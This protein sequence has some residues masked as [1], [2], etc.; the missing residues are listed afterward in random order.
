[1]TVKNLLYAGAAPDTGNLGVS[2]LCRAVVSNLLQLDSELNIYI[3]GHGKR[4]E[5]NAYDAGEG[6]CHILGAKLSNRVWEPSSLH[7]IRHTIKLGSLASSTARLFRQANALLDISGGDSFTDLYGQKRFDAVTLPK[8]IAIENNIP[9]ILLPQTYGPF[10]NPAIL[11]DSKEIV[12]RASAAYAR[13]R[14]SFEI[15]KEMLG[16]EFD[17][18]RHQ[19]AVDVA[20]LLPT[21]NDQMLID[22]RLLPADYEAESTREIAG[23]NVSGL[24]YNQPDKASSQYG[25]TLDYPKVLQDLVC[26]IAETS[27]AD[28]WLV[29]HVLAPDGHFESDSFACNR[30]K[31]SL[32][33]AVS[34]RV[35]V[36][37]GD[38]DQCDIKGVIA[39][40][41]WFTGTRMHA[42]IA[43]LS[44]QV[45]TAAVAYSGKFRGVFASAG[46]EAMALDARALTTESLTAGL[47]DS[48]TRRAE[49]RAQLQEAIP[50]LKQRTLSQFDDIYRIILNT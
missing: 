6:R 9:L 31:E 21:S 19:E 38:Y 15:M 40:T 37:K 48:W 26:H 36:I 2:A 39:K 33:K 43:S 1:M 30:L 25:I 22:K 16:D 4:L 14:Y 34:E 28:I 42:T 18:S 46:Q 20:F 50:A 49:I 45:P 5:S 7:N 12:K 44:S 23:I 8:K 17:P 3:L 27:D 13:D 35:S 24:I 41:S 10:E 29:P 11:N 32:P 47:I